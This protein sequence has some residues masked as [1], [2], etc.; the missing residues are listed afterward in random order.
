MAGV[1]FIEITVV[2]ILHAISNH[3]HKTLDES[4]LCVLP[5]STVQVAKNC[6]NLDLFAKLSATL[7]CFT[8]RKP[9]WSATYNSGSGLVLLLPFWGHFLLCLTMICKV[10]PAFLQK[11][12][13]VWWIVPLTLS[14]CTAKYTGIA[15]TSQCPLGEATAI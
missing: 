9:E 13:K 15:I 2:P 8:Q 14:R 7:W 11:F 12:Y 5:I 3:V 6:S 10:A 1:L 4:L